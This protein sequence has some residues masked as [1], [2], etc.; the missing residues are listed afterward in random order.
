MIKR[1]QMNFF[2]VSHSNVFFAFFDPKWFLFYLSPF[3]TLTMVFPLQIVPYQQ[4]QKLF[5]KTNKGIK[6]KFVPEPIGPPSWSLSRFSQSMKRQGILLLLPE[7][8]LV[9]RKATRWHFIRLP[10]RFPV[11][12]LYSW[13]ERGSVTV[14]CFAQETD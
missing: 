6:V 11:T 2:S 5:W 4:L 12:H 8:M 1:Q 10:S 14:K 13:L 9:H 3:I 7:W